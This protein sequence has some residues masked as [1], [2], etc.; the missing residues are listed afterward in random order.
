LMIPL[1][2]VLPMLSMRPARAAFTARPMA[3]CHI[4]D[5]FGEIDQFV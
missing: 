1:E 3:G 2:S 5:L 4:G